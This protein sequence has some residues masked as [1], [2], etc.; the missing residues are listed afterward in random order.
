MDSYDQAL[1]KRYFFEDVYQIPSQQLLTLELRDI[2]L[3]EGK[4]SNRTDKECQSPNGR[5]KQP[6]THATN[7]SY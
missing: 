2:D 4:M 6:K 5:E 3:F 1:F 7:K